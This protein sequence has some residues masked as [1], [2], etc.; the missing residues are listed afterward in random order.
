MK[1]PEPT[2]RARKPRKAAKAQTPAKKKKAPPRASQAALDAFQDI[3]RTTDQS[4]RM[5][6]DWNGWKRT[7]PSQPGTDSP[8]GCELR[9]QLAGLN[10]HMAQV[11]GGSVDSL[12]AG[13]GAGAGAPGYPEAV[14]HYVEGG[15]GDM[16]RDEQVRLA[17]RME[18]MLAPGDVE[19]AEWLRQQVRVQTEGADVF[20]SLLGRG[21]GEKQAP[22]AEQA[23][24]P[25][26]G[27]VDPLGWSDADD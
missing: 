4:L 1:R 23:Q 8:Q 7:H 9:R 18:R 12:M 16:V 19:G 25:Y 27:M 14:G 21:S 5:P 6:G 2:K 24:N 11:D 17:E 22:A 3:D 20:A 15:I 26:L 13:I 10:A